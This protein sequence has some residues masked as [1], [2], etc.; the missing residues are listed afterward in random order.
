MPRA[1]TWR[2]T[3]SSR[4]CV[5]WRSSF[6]GGGAKDLLERLE[7]GDR[8][9]MGQIEVQRSDGDVSVL[10][11]FEVGPFARLPG[12]R[13]AADPVVLPPPRIE[14]LDQRFGVDALAKMGH[15]HA[16]KGGGGKIHVE[17]DLRVARLLE[18]PADQLRCQL[19]GGI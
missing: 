3:I 11:R 10:H 12:R 7:T 16:L 5:N 1:L 14:P 8:L 6:R 18:E 19:C 15:P 4:R 9:V 13:A 17:D 2:S